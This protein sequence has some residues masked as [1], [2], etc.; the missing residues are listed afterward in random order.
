MFKWPLYRLTNE[1]DGQ[2]YRFKARNELQKYV[3]QLIVNLK[4]H[5]NILIAFV[6]NEILNDEFHYVTEEKNPSNFYIDMNM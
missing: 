4:Q 6:S 1:P 5:L 2:L 3:F